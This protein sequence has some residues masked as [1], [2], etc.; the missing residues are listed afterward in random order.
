MALA[1]GRAQDQLPNERLQIPATLD[2]VHRQPVKQLRVAGPVRLDPQVLHTL[3]DPGAEELLPDPV[4]HDPR[5]ERMVA[6]NQPPRQSQAPHLFSRRKRR[7]EGG[8]PGLDLLSG[9]VVLPS[10][11]DPGNTGLFFFSHDHD[12]HLWVGL[13]GHPGLSASPQVIDKALLLQVVE[14]GE[15]LVE[16]FL[17]QGIVLVLMAASAAEAQPHPNHPHGLDPVD[18]VLGAPLLVDRASLGVDAVITVKTRGDQLV[19]GRLVEQIP[20]ELLDGELIE[21]L[22]GVERPDH[23][24]SPGPL[25]VL[26]VV[27]IAMAVSIAG[28]VKPP[29]RQALSEARRCQQAIDRLRIRLW[30]LIREEGVQ[31]FQGRRQAG[32][33]K[34]SPSQELFLRGRHLGLE[35]S[36]LE[37]R[38]DKAVHHARAPADRLRQPRPHG[39]PEG[40]VLLIDRS[41]GHPILENRF[42]SFAESP[43]LAGR[44]H[45]LVFFL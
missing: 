36:R 1:I 35:P 2:K 20:G 18:D 45:D 37:T 24:V 42:F 33:V 43:P 19:V 13:V 41:L 4:H 26:E 7:Q 10:H 39:L 23:P 16:L 28:A 15:E 27:V 6:V 3:D 12:L 40:P 9:R 44:R 38:E 17:A 5:G 30:C 32:Q 34:G 8:Q 29:G 11:E 14:E 31:L 21:G 22:V 25:A